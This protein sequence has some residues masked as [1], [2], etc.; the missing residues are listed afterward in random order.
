MVGTAHY[1]PVGWAPPTTEISLRIWIDQPASAG[2][3]EPSMVGTAHHNHVEWA[4][5]TTGT[6]RRFFVP[7]GTY[8]RKYR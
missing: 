7:I 4:S 6:Y 1:S 2:A 8:F 3:T 5:P